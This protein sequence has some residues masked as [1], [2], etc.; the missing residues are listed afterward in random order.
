MARVFRN[1][2]APVRRMRQQ[3]R[4]IAMLNGACLR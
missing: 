4:E 3:R 2:A 1:Q